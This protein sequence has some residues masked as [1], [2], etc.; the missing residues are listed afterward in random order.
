MMW[1]RFPHRWIHD[2]HG[3]GGGGDGNGDDDTGGRHKAVFKVELVFA[4]VSTSRIHSASS[5]WKNEDT[6][7]LRL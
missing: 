1:I 2:Y 4:S 6:A 5:A 7:S 3:G